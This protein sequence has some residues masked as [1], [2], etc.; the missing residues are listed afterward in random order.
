[1][2]TFA[3]L[4]LDAGRTSD[5]TQLVSADGVAAMQRPQVESPDRYTLGSH[6]GLGVILF[7]WDGHRVYGHDG[8]TIGQ[9][10]MLRIVP[11]AGLA[12][13]LLVNG[14][15]VQPVYR[16]IFGELAGELAGIA[17]PPP[18]EAPAQPPALDLEPLCR[19]VPTSVRALRPVPRGRSPRRHGRRSAARSP[20][21]RPTR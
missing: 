10:S 17:M 1:M 3:R 14:G 4:H 15:D 9:S 21:W 13:C 12:M 2:L 5:G 18:L 19:D 8:A 6:W 7:D 16:T 20:P 11:E